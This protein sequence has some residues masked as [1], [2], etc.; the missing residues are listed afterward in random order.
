MIPIFTANGRLISYAGRTVHKGVRP[1]TRKCHSPHKTLYGAYELGL[2]YGERNRPVV[3]VEGEF[4][5]MYLQRYHVPAVAQVGTHELTCSQISLLRSLT[6]TVV[7]SYDGDE[8][9]EAALSKSM[10]VL[11]PWFRTIAIRLPEGRDPNDLTPKEVKET[12]AEYVTTF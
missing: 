7:L 12:Y 11:G 1:K 8:A 9:G 2:Q 4:D 3:I 10:E 5:A 6:R